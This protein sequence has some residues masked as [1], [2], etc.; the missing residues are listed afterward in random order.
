MR[1]GATIRRVAKCPSPTLSCS[2]M[3]QERLRCF[4]EQ[5]A[6]M[7]VGC[8]DEASGHVVAKERDAY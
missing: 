1:I 2:R 5:G 6:A 8:D 4:R 7:A 3:R